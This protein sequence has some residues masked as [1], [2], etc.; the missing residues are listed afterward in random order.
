MSKREC[1]I[2]CDYLPFNIIQGALCGLIFSAVLTFW[3]GI[4]GTILLPVPP[5]TGVSTA[6]CDMF[7]KN[8]NGTLFNATDLN[9][10]STAMMSSISTSAVPTTM[11]T[12]ASPEDFL[13]ELESHQ[14][15]FFF[16]IFS[17]KFTITVR[18]TRETLNILRRTFF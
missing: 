12:P 15:I 6:K 8:C 3:V 18:E 14:F 13:L 17:N 10:T 7:P 2:P 4:G 9:Y 1:H 16:F 11:D 5:V